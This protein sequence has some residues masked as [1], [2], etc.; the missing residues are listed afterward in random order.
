M[1]NVRQCGQGMTSRRSPLK[2]NVSCCEPNPALPASDTANE[3]WPTSGCSRAKAARVSGSRR[4]NCGLRRQARPDRRLAEYR[5]CNPTVPSGLWT[6]DPGPWT[7]DPPLHPAPTRSPTISLVFS[8]RPPYPTLPYSTPP[9]TTLPHFPRQS[10]LPP[11]APLRRM[12]FVQKR[13]TIHP[14]TAPPTAPPTPASGSFRRSIPWSLATRPKP[15]VRLC[16]CVPLLHLLHAV[17]GNP[18]PP[19]SARPCT[20]HHRPS[21]SS[22]D[23]HFYSWTPQLSCNL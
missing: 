16:Y 12:A 14:A 11:H 18:S 17:L 20:Q 9:S 8:T 21:A 5:R 2:E 22:F 6:L 15:V 19:E 1:S 3:I 13:A 7:L 10:P 23:P 4:G